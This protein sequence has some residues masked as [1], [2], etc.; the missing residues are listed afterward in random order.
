[1]EAE[2]PSSTRVGTSDSCSGSEGKVA[3]LKVSLRAQQRS[4]AD[5]ALCRSLAQLLVSYDHKDGGQRH[6]SRYVA[7]KGFSDTW[8]SGHLRV[9]RWEQATHPEGGNPESLRQRHVVPVW[10]L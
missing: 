6:A 3:S 10:H 4:T 2:K 5:K 9:T 7:F 8:A 1:M